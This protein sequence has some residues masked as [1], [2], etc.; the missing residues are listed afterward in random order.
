MLI[1]R[2]PAG[3]YFLWVDIKT[4]QISGTLSELKKKLEARGVHVLYGDECSV[5]CNNA[6]RLCFSFLGKEQ[7]EKGVHEISGSINEY[8]G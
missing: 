7:I 1:F 3:G 4:P 8:L 5:N 6:F 2:K